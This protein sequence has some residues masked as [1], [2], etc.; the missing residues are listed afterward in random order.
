MKTVIIFREREGADWLGAGTLNGHPLIR[1]LNM[2]DLEL[3]RG[4]ARRLFRAFGRFD[5]RVVGAPMSEA[6]AL[7]ALH[8]E[9]AGDKP[10][11][12]RAP[13]GARE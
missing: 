7:R 9:L 4:A 6:E 1:P 5:L 11:V 2:G 8:A 10:I 12:R 13:I 3:A